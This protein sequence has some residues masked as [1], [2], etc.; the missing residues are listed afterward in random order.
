MG[1]NKEQKDKT[2]TCHRG[3]GK[4][5]SNGDCSVRKKNNMCPAGH[6]CKRL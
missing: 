4:I 1:N 2:T 5:S 3:N 6:P